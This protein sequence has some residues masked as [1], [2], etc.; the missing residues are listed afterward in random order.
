MQVYKHMDIG[1]AKI[2]PDEMSGVPHHMIDILEP[3]ETFSAFDFKNRAQQL[4]TEI[5]R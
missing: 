5:T 2:T 3:D 1:T 4:I